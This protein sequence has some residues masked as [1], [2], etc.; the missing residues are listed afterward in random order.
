ML[1]IDQLPTIPMGD[2]DFWRDPYP[3]LAE[4]REHHRVAKLP[5]GNVAVLRW[6]DAF[7]VVRGVQFVQ[8]GI[9]ALERMGFQAGDPLHT[10][11]K[12][13]I[14]VLEGESHRRVRSLAAWALNMRRMNELRPMI[15]RHAHALLDEQVGDGELDALAFAYSLPRLVMME[16]L[17]VSGEELDPVSPR[18]GSSVIDAFGGGEMTPEVRAMVNDGIQHAME[19]TAMLYERRRQEP[20]DDLLTHL[21]QAESDEGALTQGELITLFSSIFGSGTSTASV[22]ASG[23]LE[24]ARWPDQAALLREDPEQ[25]KHGASEESLRYRPAIDR[26]PKKATSDTEAFGMEFAEGDVVTT[27]I[28]SVNRDPRKWSDPDSFDITRPDSGAAHLTFGIGPHVCLGHAMARATIEEGLAV[29]VE[30]CDSIE[31]LEEPRWKPFVM[32]NKLED[33]EFHLR[34]RA[35]ARA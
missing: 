8:E 24:L 4:I 7:D 27:L 22:L 29:F 26:I 12:D 11:A 9:E 3:V 10:W 23:M 1:T 14:G 5:D 35:T 2:A 20:R 33:E 21:V 31:L 30:R 32:E 13:R 15:V 19:H 18:G 28:K 34:V 25:W 16:H 17:G 6:E